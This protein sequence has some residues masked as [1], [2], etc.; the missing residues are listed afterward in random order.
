MEKSGTIFILIS[1]PQELKETVLKI[2]NARITS[3]KS[4]A[5]KT[6][7]KANMIG[8]ENLRNLKL[9]TKLYVRI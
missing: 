1:I 7:Q 8:G 5:D 2:V 4:K 6:Y 9:I 3:E